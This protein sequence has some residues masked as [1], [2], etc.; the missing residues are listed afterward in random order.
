M[1]ELTNTE[2]AA[3]LKESAQSDDDSAFREELAEAVGRLLTA[4]QQDH[5][6]LA[7]GEQRWADLLENIVALASE[8][9]GDTSLP[10]CLWEALRDAELAL[11]TR[12]N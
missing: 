12:R 2:L 9:M 11:A 7:N 5:D 1:T 4:R 6:L 8:K 10:A 3:E